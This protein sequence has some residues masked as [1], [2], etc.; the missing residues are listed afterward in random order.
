MWTTF[1]KP[2]PWAVEFV[3][4][5]RPGNSIVRYRG[6]EISIP[7][8][9]LFESESDAWLA[10]YSKADADCHVM[11]QRCTHLLAKYKEAKKREASRPRNK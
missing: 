7:D 3:R 2:S 10:L 5:G 6:D 1:G 4:A 8:S 11:M 9:T